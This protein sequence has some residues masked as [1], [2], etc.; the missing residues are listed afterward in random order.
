MNLREL[1]KA[2]LKSQGFD[3]L[4]YGSYGNCGCE[5]D[6]LMPCGG[7]SLSCTAGYKHVISVDGIP[8]WVI[9]E[10]K[11]PLTERQMNEL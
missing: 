1:L 4:Y 5:I 7:P 3:G 11:G 9:T 8:T 6:D 10:T 2:Q